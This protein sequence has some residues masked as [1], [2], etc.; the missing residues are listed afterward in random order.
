MV[1]LLLLLLGLIVLL[2]SYLMFSLSRNQRE[3]QGKVAYLLRCNQQRR[4][5]PNRRKT[6]AERGRTR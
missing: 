3:L 4:P 1:Y 2:Q 5:K 6:E